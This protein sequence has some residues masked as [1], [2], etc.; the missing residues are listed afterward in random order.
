MCRDCELC[1]VRL[2]EDAFATGPLGVV[3]STAGVVVS[4]TVGVVV[5]STVGVVVSLSL[6]VVVS[7]SEESLVSESVEELL[8]ESLEESLSESVDELSSSEALVEDS[9]DSDVLEEPNS[10]PEYSKALSAMLLNGTS[11]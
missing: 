10:V 11:L 8:S 9:A 7:E 2:P 1:V 4:S 3:S 5:S 6:C